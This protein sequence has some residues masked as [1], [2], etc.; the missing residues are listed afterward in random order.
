MARSFEQIYAEAPK[1]AIGRLLAFR[2]RY[3]PHYE[4]YGGKLYKT[5][6]INEAQLPQGEERT[7]VFFPSAMGHGEIWFPYMLELRDK[8]RVIAFSL[9]DDEEPEAL[10]A[11]FLQILSNIGVDKMM[12][13]ANSVGGLLAQIMAAKEPDRVVALALMMTGCPAEDLD[14]ATKQNWE[15]RRKLKRRLRFQSYSPGHRLGMASSIFEATCPEQYKDS[16]TFWMG[17]IEETFADAV[18]KAQHVAINA[19]LVPNIY[20]K[21]EFTAEDFTRDMPVLI[22]ESQSDNLYSAKERA[23]LKDVFPQ[24]RVEEMGDAGQFALQLHEQRATEILADFVKG[25]FV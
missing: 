6:D 20:A 9:A 14:F 1:P 22:M 5:W 18:Y 13:A 7:I 17:Y 24:A 11:A 25:V 15:R 2:E 3:A 12:I 23:C 10:A 4:E 16:A 8:A 19:D 21:Y